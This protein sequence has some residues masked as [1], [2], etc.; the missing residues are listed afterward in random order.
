MH[1]IN[2]LYQMSNKTSK[3]MTDRIFRLPGRYLRSRNSRGRAVT[4]IRGIGRQT[5]QTMT[6]ADIMLDTPKT[7]SARGVYQGFPHPLD[8]A[9]VVRVKNYLLLASRSRSVGVVALLSFII[10]CHSQ[11]SRTVR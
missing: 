10:G 4:R 8:L 7:D 9:A 2:R 3:N 1:A 11:F 5:D 6:T